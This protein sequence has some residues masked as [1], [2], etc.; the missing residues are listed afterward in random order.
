MSRTV[1]AR[2]AR[3]SKSA[4][5]PDRFSPRDLLGALRRLA[6]DARQA[7]RAGLRMRALTR[8]TPGSLGMLLEQRAREAPHR[9]ALVFEGSK[10]SYREFNAWSNRIAARLRAAGVQRG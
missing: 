2:P 1:G 7:T 3:D 4:S 6:P 9:T 5:T 8:E 10:W